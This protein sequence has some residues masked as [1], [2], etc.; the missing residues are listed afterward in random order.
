M[1]KITYRNLSGYKYALME[2]YTYET[3]FSLPKPVAEPDGW[4]S[5][6]AAG[7]LAL[8]R[9]YAWDGPSGPTLDTKD[10]MRGSL[11]H[12]ALYQLLRLKLLDRGLRK[13]A[14]ELLWMLCLEDGMPKVRANYVFHAVRAFG[15]SAARPPR[16]PKKIRITAP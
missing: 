11:V 9:G 14:D 15:A 3:G 16:K 2:K 13:R 12:D 8:K 5:M 1:P 10:L 7:R 4:V 6:S